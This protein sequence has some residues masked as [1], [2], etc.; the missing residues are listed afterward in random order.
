MKTNI[1]RISIIGFALTFITSLCLAIFALFGAPIAPSV[2]ASAAASAKITKVTWTAGTG[3]GYVHL[4]TD[5]SDSTSIGNINANAYLDKWRYKNITVNG[6]SAVNGGAW[7]N[8]GYF[9]TN[10]GY[11]RYQ[12]WLANADVVS[13]ASTVTPAADGNKYLNYTLKAGASVGGCSVSG[14]VAKAALSR[15]MFGSG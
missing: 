3:G 13:D 9:N 5:I 10:G 14:A 4:Y 15:G 7:D 6:V 2:T 11:H 12:M 1:K 8:G